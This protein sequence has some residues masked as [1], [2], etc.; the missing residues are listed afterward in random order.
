MGL[1]R[2][3]ARR[4]QSADLPRRRQGLGR[5]RLRQGH[6]QGN[7]ESSVRER[8]RLRAAHDLRDRRQ[9]PA[10]LW[11]PESINSLNPETGQCYWS[12]KYGTKKA[13]KADLS[14][15]T[16]RLAGDRLF[17]TAFYDG[18]LMLKLNGTQQPSVAWQGQ[19]RGEKP[20]D[21][22]GLH[23]IMST[24]FLKDGHI[25][26]VCSYGELRCL[27]AATG[28]RLWATHAA[29]T[30]KSVRWG[31]AFLVQFQNTGSLRPVQR[32]GRPDPR[33][34]DAQGLQG[35]QPRQHP[36]A[37]EHDGRPAGRK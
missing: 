24:P 8:A 12:Q 2:P 21:T 3:S 20:D 11:H 30:G 27:D 6:R 37:D 25:Y 28:K 17:F 4:R 15:P 22:D 35:D 23:S 5:R 9:A 14:I 13:L 18:P 7:L 33:R 36:G 26:G 32:A 34:A 16:P 19:G 1:R 10:D 29:T 31:H